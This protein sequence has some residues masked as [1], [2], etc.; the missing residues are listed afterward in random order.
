MIRSGR[1]RL[2][3]QIT[4]LLLA[5]G[6]AGCVT[7]TGRVFTDP[8]APE[9][10]LERRVELAR[11]YIGE[12]DWDNA[13]RNLAQAAAID[14]NNAEVHEAFALVYQSTGEEELA[15]KSFRK[16]IQLNRKFSRARNN[17]AAF[18]FAQQRYQE[19]E[20][21]LELVVQDPLYTARPRAYMNL[22]L[23]RLQLDQPESAEQAFSRALSMDRTNTVA[24]LEM[25]ILRYDA[26]DYSAA[27]RY[28]GVYRTAVRRQSARGLW[29]GIRLA[30]ATGDRNAEGSYVLALGSLYPDSPEYREFLQA[31]Q[32]GE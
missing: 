15:E 18:L 6:C 14:S 13:K 17:Y 32:D 20:K 9:K 4:G 22:G 11:Q 1:R 8:P 5:L 26:G 27:S 2:P 10:A 3:W 30:Q 21:E 28:Y 24:L 19:A 12:G 31:R 23:C 16:A 29:L 25:A 7:N